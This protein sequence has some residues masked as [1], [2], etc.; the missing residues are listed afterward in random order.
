MKFSHICF[1]VAMVFGFLAVLTLLGLMSS[2]TEDAPSYLL[3]RWNGNLA[4]W[5]AIFFVAMVLG[6]ISWLLEERSDNARKERIKAAEAKDDAVI[7]AANNERNTAQLL[8]R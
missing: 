4:T 7:R 3:D 8:G 5:G 2:R 1:A 6:L